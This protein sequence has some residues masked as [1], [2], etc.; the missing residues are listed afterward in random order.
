MI[1]VDDDVSDCPLRTVPEMIEPKS[2]PRVS[3][4]RDPPA[5]YKRWNMRF[6]VFE[7]YQTYESQQLLRHR[8]GA[9][10][11]SVGHFE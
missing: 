11:V 4:V 9:T 3:D 6:G 7:D 2:A 1:Y 5:Q 8:T 10:H